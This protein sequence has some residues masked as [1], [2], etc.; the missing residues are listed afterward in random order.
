MLAKSQF[1]IQMSGGISHNT[2]KGH[3]LTAVCKQP[4]DGVLDKLCSDAVSLVCLF[5][6]HRTDLIAFQQECTDNFATLCIYKSPVSGIVPIRT[7][8]IIRLFRFGVRKPAGLQAHL[9]K[10]I[11]THIMGF[12]KVPAL[13]AANGE[14]R[15]R[16][17]F[18]AI[19]HI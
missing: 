12:L 14:I 8:F 7:G 3:F 15:K 18:S 16:P 2:V 1:I 5:H 10:C 9:V 13:I 4:V 17:A 19:G 6:S 11:C